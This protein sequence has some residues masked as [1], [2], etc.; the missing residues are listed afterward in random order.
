MNSNNDPVVIAKKL[1]GEG[2]LFL[3][4]KIIF[5]DYYASNCLSNSEV[6]II[7][8]ERRQK[9]ENAEDDIKQVVLT[10]LDDTIAYSK[11]RDPI[12]EKPRIEELRKSLESFELTYNDDYSSVGR[13]DEFEVASLMNLVPEE[14]EEATCI[15]P[16]LKRFTTDSID[17]L[18]RVL[19]DK[20]ND[21]YEFN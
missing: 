10:T 15:I 7:L 6:A 3:F 16:S 1:R 12:Q 19:L 21:D 4:L 13:L 20:E 14:T 18:I 2:I 8:S 5:I 17:D 9:T 11:L